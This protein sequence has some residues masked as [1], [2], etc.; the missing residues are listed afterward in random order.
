MGTLAGVT[1]YISTTAAGDSTLDQSGFEALSYTQ[2]KNVGSL[3]EYGRNENIAEY[4]T[5]D[6]GVL[7]S[8]GSNNAGQGDIELAYDPDDAGQILM[9]TA[10]ASAN[11]YAFKI[12]YDDDQTGSPVQPTTDYLRGIISGPRFP[13]G[14]DE[15]FHRELYTISSDQHLRIVAA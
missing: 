12:V 13:T 7:K 1:L 8:K 3:P 11:K 10:G 2:V 15:D 5:L 4:R 14:G 6:Q 9:R